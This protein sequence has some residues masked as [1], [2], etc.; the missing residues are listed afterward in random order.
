MLKARDREE[1]S[2]LMGVCGLVWG[3]LRGVAFDWLER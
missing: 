2:A 1:L 3:A